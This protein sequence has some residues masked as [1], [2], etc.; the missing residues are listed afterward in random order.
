MP[1]SFLN[2]ATIK[3]TIA[4][5]KWSPPRWLSPFVAFTSKTP[6]PSSRIETSN[7]PPPRS[8][9]RIVWSVLSLSR[10]YASAAAVG[11][12]MMRTTLSPAIL[13]ASLGAS[14]CA[15]R[16]V[17]VGR[18]GDYRVGDRLAEIGLGIRL[19]LLKDHRRDLRR[20]VLLALGL[21]AHVAVL[22]LDDLLRDDLHLL[23]H[24]AE[25]TAHEALDR[26]DRVLR[27]RHLLPLGRRADAPLPLLRDRDDGRRRASALGVRNDGRLT[28]LE[29][30]HAAVG[31]SEVDSNGLRHVH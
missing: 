5:A 7:V 27:V 2:S 26:E 30:G 15:L 6:S 25:L 23:G 29:H 20:R 28:A 13:P 17:E 3:S 12:L 22:A 4:L 11:S 24:L 21:D 19:Q 18:D 9:T 16:F 31:R 8:K 14:R 10:P 1:W